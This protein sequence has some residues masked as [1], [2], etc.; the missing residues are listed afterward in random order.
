[1]FFLFFLFFIFFIQIQKT[2]KSIFVFF[3]FLQE[4]CL[5]FFCSFRFRNK[6]TPKSLIFLMELSFF[7][8]VGFETWT[9]NEKPNDSDWVFV[10]VFWFRNLNKNNKNRIVLIEAYV[11]VFHFLVS[12]QTKN[13]KSRSCMNVEEHECMHV[14]SVCM[15][16]CASF[17]KMRACMPA[18]HTYASLDWRA[19]PHLFSNE[20][21]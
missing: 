15:Q 17:E 16:S 9:K 6:Q 21:T 11:S 19:C 14:C 7:S 18:D 12:K 20:S 13:F 8:F 1:M 3:V 5:S 2:N 10:F 4:T